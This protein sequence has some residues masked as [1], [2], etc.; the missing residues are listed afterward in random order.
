MFW[1]LTASL[2]L[3]LFVVNVAWLLPEYR[4]SEERA[5]KRLHS[6]AGTIVRA[7]DRLASANVAPRDFATLAEQVA[8]GTL[9][10]GGAIYDANGAFV[11]AFGEMPALKPARSG[12]STGRA[13][14][15]LTVGNRHDI[16]WRLV[17]QGTPYY[18]VVRTDSSIVEATRSIVLHQIFAGA[19]ASALLAA[20]AVLA[21]MGRTLLGPIYRLH[22]AVTRRDATL[23]DSRLL[24]ERGEIGDIARSVRAYIAAHEK[25]AVPQPEPEDAA[26]REP[27]DA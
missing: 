17:D 23:V 26:S 16:V 7:L 3:V 9:L 14:Q 22:R 2:M 6:E 24:A 21:L 20:L 4:A 25:G 19:A 13:Q 5:L 15:R 11:H 12:V 18:V 1:E 8:P 27:A 10:K